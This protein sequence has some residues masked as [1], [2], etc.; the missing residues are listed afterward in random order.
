MTASP[1]KTARTTA[2]MRRHTATPVS[3]LLQKLY[4]LAAQNP[5]K[6][7]GQTVEALSPRAELLGRTRR[8]LGV[9]A[10]RKLVGNSRHRPPASAIL[11]ICRN[12]RNRCGHAHAP[13]QPSRRPPG[14]SRA[15]ARRSSRASGSP[16]SQD[17]GRRAAAHQRPPRMAPHR[18]RIEC[19]KGHEGRDHRY[20][21]R[22]QPSDVAGLHPDAAR[23]IPQGRVG[24]HQQ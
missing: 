24:V 12:R 2:G 14:R 6:P 22:H 5:G 3:S 23:R 19:R 10:P 7:V 9:R 17:N 13:G 21:R 8:L 15:P 18:R 16:V 20:R 4:A 1:V 11:G